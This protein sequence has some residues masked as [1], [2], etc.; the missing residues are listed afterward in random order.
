ML[1]GTSVSLLLNNKVLKIT[2]HL[3][4]SVFVVKSQNFSENKVFY[5]KDLKKTYACENCK[6]TKIKREKCILIKST[7]SETKNISVASRKLGVS[8][9]TI[10]KHLK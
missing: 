8:R 7:F 5:N 2:D 10:Y 6:D 3:G 1:E 4:S 9:T